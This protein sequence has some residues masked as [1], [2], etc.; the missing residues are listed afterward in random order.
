VVLPKFVAAVVFDDSDLAP[1]AATP[2]MSGAVGT[3][4]PTGQ[5]ALAMGLVSTAAIGAAGSMAQRWLARSKASLANK[6][7]EDSI[8]NKAK[9][10]KIGGSRYAVV[11]L[12]RHEVDRRAS[13]PK[14]TKPMPESP[15]SPKASIIDIKL[16]KQ[17]QSS[18]NA[19]SL[20]IPLDT[21]AMASIHVK[22]IELSTNDRQ[23]R[24]KQVQEHHTPGNSV[25]KLTEDHVLDLIMHLTEGQLHDL[26]LDD[27]HQNVAAV[28]AATSGS[29]QSTKLKSTKLKSTKLKSSDQSSG[30][31]KVKEHTIEEYRNRD[32]IKHQK[33]LAFMPETPFHTRR[34]QHWGNIK[35]HFITRND[36]ESDITSSSNE[37]AVILKKGKKEMERR[38]LFDYNQNNDTSAY[39]H[40]N[41]TSDYNHNTCNKTSESVL[42]DLQLKSL[43]ELRVQRQDT[44]L[45]IELRKRSAAVKDMEARQKAFMAAAAAGTDT[46]NGD[47]VNV[48][49][50][51]Q[52]K[53]ANT[54]GRK[55]EK[56]TNKANKEKSVAIKDM[57][58][59][60]KAFLAA[61]AAGT[62]TINGDTVN[63]LKSV[64]AKHAHLE[65]NSLQKGRI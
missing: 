32:T 43:Q 22:E 62:D 58:A 37:W 16:L 7:L 24:Q 54:E 42:A 47:T 14:K 41:N 50:R 64:Q 45:N 46:I 57:E 31:T 20:A 10:G 28:V 29:D 6:K 15:E 65:Q 55:K 12:H 34:M 18:K 4:G 60:Q 8:L 53:H 51:V 5:M 1:L 40:N 26:M 59:R 21:T 19:V 48:L 49:K 13:K 25:Q 56:R 27:T 35:N 39:N 3:L 9:E 11:P 52:A 17:G 44:E 38:R 61:A 23:N 36:S 63:V 30:C 2:L 33:E